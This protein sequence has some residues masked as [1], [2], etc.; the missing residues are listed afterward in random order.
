MK[1]LGLGLFLLVTVIGRCTS[2]GNTPPVKPADLTLTG[3]TVFTGAEVLSDAWVSITDGRISGLGRENPPGATR[4][5]DARG[6]TI[7]PGLTDAHAHLY[8]LGL[9]LDTVSLVETTSSEEAVARVR[10]RAG[11]AA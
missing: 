4:T 6:T 3:A 10:D 2:G 5:I 1:R 9:A 7:L 8:G 11:R